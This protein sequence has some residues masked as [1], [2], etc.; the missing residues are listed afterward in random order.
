[1]KK[2]TLLTAV[3]AF[4]LMA[5]FTACR[6]DD[7]LA[8]IESSRPTSLSFTRVTF[9]FFS[10]DFITSLL[11]GDV[12]AQGVHVYAEIGTGGLWMSLPAMLSSSAGS[13]EHFHYFRIEAGN[14]R[15]FAEGDD[16]TPSSRTF[17]LVVVKQQNKHLGVDF[18]DYS[19]VKAA[20]NLPDVPVAIID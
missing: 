2:T 6:K 18:S 12:S 14:V 11:S 4:F 1:M 13:V 17:R 5:N 15:I 7:N 20:F 10:T 9:G 19:A 3:T 8:T 16:S